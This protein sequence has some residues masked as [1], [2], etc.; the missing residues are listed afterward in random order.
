MKPVKLRIQAFGPYQNEVTID[1]RNISDNLFLISGDTGAGKT[2][3]FDAMCY[4]LYG[5][6][7]GDKKAAQSRNMSAD[8]KTKTEVEFLFSHNGNEYTVMRSMR[9]LIHKDGTSEIKHDACSLMGTDILPIS[10]GQDITNKITELIGYDA[11]QFKQV[12]L[13]QQGDFK[14]FLDAD[15][16]EKLQILGKLFG[17]DEYIA[18]QNR[19]KYAKERLERA[20][21]ADVESVNNHLTSSTFLLPEDMSEAERLIF[22]L[23]PDCSNADELMS[24]LETLVK[25]DAEKLAGAN[26]S[27][28]EAEKEH[29][30]LNTLLAT[31]RLQNS[32]LDSLE[33]EREKQ[34]ELE[35]HTEE[36]EI[37]KA[38]IDVAENAY[39]NVYPFY[40]D[41]EK[42]EASLIGLKSEKAELEDKLV[43]LGENLKTADDKKRENP[44]LQTKINNNSIE[45]SELQKAVDVFAKIERDESVLNKSLYAQKLALSDKENYEQIIA[46]KKSE[47]EKAADELK[48]YDG[49]DE[50]VKSCKE[51]YDAQIEKYRKLKS[52]GVNDLK[53]LADK[54]KELKGAYLTHDNNLRVKKMYADE[55]LEMYESFIDAQAGILGGEIK[56]EIMR[57]GESKCKVCGKKLI[58]SDI[59]TL[60]VPPENIPTKDEVDAAAER[61]RAA[62][63]NA[64]KSATDAEKKRTELDAMFSSV[65]KSVSELVGDECP[66]ENLGGFIK[67]KLEE[68]ATEG[69]KIRSDKDC[70]EETKKRRDYVRENEKVLKTSLPND[71]E[72]QRKAA[73]SLD[74]IKSEIGTLTA[75]ITL[76]K[77]SVEKYPDKMAAV[78]RG[79]ALK[80]ENITLER[81]LEENDKRYNELNEQ[82]SK[83]SGSLAT[84]SGRL[85]DTENELESKLKLYEKSL[86]D[87]DFSDEK[88]FKSYVDALIEKQKNSG[89]DIS[90]VIR[91]ERNAILE[92]H[93]NVKECAKSVE[94]LEKQTDG[95]ERRNESEIVEKIEKISAEKETALE[96]RDRINSV[97]TTHETTSKE[98][99]QKIENAAKYTAAYNRVAKLSDIANGTVSGE[100]RLSFDTYVIGED[101]KLILAEAN[102]RLSLLSDGR[103]ELLHRVEGSKVGKSGLDIDVYDNF[104]GKTRSSK[105]LSGG[106][107]FLVSLSLA[108]GLSDVVRS[109]ANGNKIDAMFID[110]GFGTLDDDRLD[111]TIY[112]LKK[113]SDGNQ[114]VGIISHVDKLE[115]SISSKILVKSKNGVSSI[116]IVN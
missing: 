16:A 22:R 52:I 113:L 79:R 64:S 89:E 66:I 84:V 57:L 37:R 71:E 21:K 60:A 108:L 83:I 39:S 114:M 68:I 2:T 43:I 29:N 28:R 54:D 1:F 34:K 17:T 109:R 65:R 58:K 94:R 24:A 31:A 44:I 13:L 102:K 115:S 30:E 46:Q 59:P 98:V 26:K 90:S 72:K 110:E 38:W 104:G 5:V 87:N 41:L 100:Q 42:T 116:D 86:A 70:L 91:H 85:S 63:E 97:Y 77:K 82:K 47:I 88:E 6:T 112:I 101:F 10:K 51:K 67:E 81:T 12:I 55:Y 35:S 25:T 62:D 61:S 78:Q 75:R 33:Q 15:S 107:G 20:I 76:N 19:L 73:E 3:I 14:K 69:K 4:A 103:Y 96:E 106:E 32:S 56:S 92:Y 7:T 53:M 74:S 95:F 105:T 27:Y 9:L 40:N 49:V 80:A 48:L 50:K 11:N 36:Y 23:S 8:S 99:K 18:F 93:Y 111:A 45:L